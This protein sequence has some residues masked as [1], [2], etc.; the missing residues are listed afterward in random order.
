MQANLDERYTWEG[1]EYGPGECVIPEA[2][3]QALGLKTAAPAVFKTESLSDLAGKTLGEL[4]GVPD[5]ATS[6][7]SGTGKKSSSHN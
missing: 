1:R 7:R 6:P 2:L 5:T 3:A 4:H